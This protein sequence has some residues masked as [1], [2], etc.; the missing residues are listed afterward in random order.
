MFPLDGVAKGIQAKFNIAKVLGIKI[1]CV[2]RF[3]EKT[4]LK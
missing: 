2:E 3:L 1:N 4:G